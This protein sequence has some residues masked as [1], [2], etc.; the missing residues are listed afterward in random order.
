MDLL[1]P[2]VKMSKSNANENG[3][4]FL[5][6]AP[7]LATKKIMGAKTD[8]LNKVIF[9]E[10]NQPGISNLLTIY[11]C[12]EDKTIPAIVKQFENKNYGEFK[13]ALAQIVSEFLT[14]FQKKY[15]KAIADQTSLT[16]QLF[17]N[18][19]KCQII[20]NKKLAQVYQAIGMT[21]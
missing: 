3:T 2:T 17:S 7:A 14:S 20:S 18:A 9:D 1:N 21:K 8:S 12:L 13:K 11:S 4:I 19:N 6:D 10:K 15:Q 16:N 5:S